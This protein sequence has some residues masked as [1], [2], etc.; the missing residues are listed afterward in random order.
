VRRRQLRDFTR[1]PVPRLRSVEPALLLSII[2]TFTVVVVVVTIGCIMHNRIFDRYLM[3]ITP[4]AAAA[5]LWGVRSGF[6]PTAVEQPAARRAAGAGGAATAALATLAIL[7]VGFVAG[8]A[9][10][11]GAKWRLGERA[12]AAGFAA[13][14]VDA[15]LEW[16]GLHQPAPVVMQVTTLTEDSWWVTGLFADPHVCAVSTYLPPDAVT[17]PRTDANMPGEGPVL[18]K[19]KAWAP[20]AGPYELGLR[21][22]DLSCATR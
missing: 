22:T 15:S 11:D 18:A 12:V 8:S 16:F 5:I 9:S 3:P 2:F 1:A 14:S 10:L 21:R 17:E 19:E 13:E 6:G 4:Y 7:G 20:L